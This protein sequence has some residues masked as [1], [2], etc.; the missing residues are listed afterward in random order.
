M[1]REMAALREENVRLTHSMQVRAWG[2]RGALPA[3]ALTGARCSS[4]TTR[5]EPHQGGN[6]HGAK[7][8]TH[9]CARALLG[10]PAGAAVAWHGSHA[11]PD[12]RTAGSDGGRRLLMCMHGAERWVGN[13]PSHSSA[14]VTGSLSP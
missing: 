11:K 5:N 7:S 1:Q 13:A 8:H 14:C 4:A 10:R 6:L 3:R 12:N 2:P 9:T